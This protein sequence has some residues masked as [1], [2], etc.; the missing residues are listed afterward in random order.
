MT[1]PDQPD[2]PTGADL[3]Q[4]AAWSVDSL[5]SAGGDWAASI[6]GLDWTVTEAVTHL[7][8]GCLWYASTWRPGA[9]T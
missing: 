2:R 5:R 3:A 9:P 4:A 1:S 7:A 6:P 8:G